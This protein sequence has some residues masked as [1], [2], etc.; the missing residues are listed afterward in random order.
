MGLIKNDN[1]QDDGVF[2]NKNPKLFSR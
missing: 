1:R 2:R